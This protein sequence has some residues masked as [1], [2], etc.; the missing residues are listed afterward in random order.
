MS[1]LEFEVMGGMHV[2]SSYEIVLHEHALLLLGSYS[3]T[4]NLSFSGG[5][6]QIRTWSIHYGAIRLW[7]FHC[8]SFSYTSKHS[9]S[10]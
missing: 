2:V 4:G 7:C 10:E 1:V 9:S 8:I 6:N 3:T 5:K